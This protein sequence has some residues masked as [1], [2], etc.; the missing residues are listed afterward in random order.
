MS[1]TRLLIL[2]VLCVAII[3]LARQWFVVSTRRDNNDDAI[4]V[5]LKVDRQKIEDDRDA[6]IDKAKDLEEDLE[7]RINRSESRKDDLEL[8][9]KNLNSNST[10]DKT[11]PES[12]LP[13]N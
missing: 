6:V 9:R 4:N 12:S 11:L 1:L 7:Q 5:N 13:D 3:G 10:S 2:I 8:R